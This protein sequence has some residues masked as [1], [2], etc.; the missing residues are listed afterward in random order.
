MPPQFIYD[1][2]VV[3][4]DPVAADYMGWKI[5]DEQRVMRGLRPL[6]ETG[7]SPKFLETAAKLGLGTND[8]NN[9]EL[10]MI[11]EGKAVQLQDTL[12]A[13]WGKIKAR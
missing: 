8:P 1:G 12:F 6:A 13:T 10:I 4:Q 11:G 5:V 9:M 2:L 3:S 7:R